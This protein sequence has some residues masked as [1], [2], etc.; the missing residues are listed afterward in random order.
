MFSP[1]GFFDFISGLPHY[2]GHRQVVTRMNHR[3]RF[4]IEAFAS[5]IA[6]ADVLDLASHDGRWAYAF[7]GAGAARV[8]GIEAR[9]ELIDRF[10]DY[11]DADL[12]QRVELR[13]GDIFDGIAAEV[14]AGSRFDVVAVFGIFYHIMDH[15]HLLRLILGLKPQLIIIDS[16][17]ALR[18]G[19][20]IQLVREKTDNILNAAP[21][22]AGQ[23]K[24][25]KGVPSFSALTMMAQALDLDV[26][27]SDWDSLPAGERSGVTDYYRTQRLRRATCALRPKGAHRS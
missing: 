10:A 24:A 13:C 11:P 27:W 8:L 18:D 4:L 26:E 20:I 23:K 2:E 6:G 16:E 19:P 9:Q 1:Q 3:H 22:I 14:A 17:F 7:A 12:R 21:Q 15:F 25:I 5:D